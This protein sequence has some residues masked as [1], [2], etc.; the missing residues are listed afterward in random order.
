MHANHKMLTYTQSSSVDTLTGHRGTLTSHASKLRNTGKQCAALL[1]AVE[2]GAGREK[3]VCTVWRV[4]FGCFSLPLAWPSE[5]SREV[6]RG[7][8]PR[9]GQAGG[10][11]N[12]SAAT[13]RVEH[14]KH[15]RGESNAA[16]S[17]GKR[18]C[19]VCSSN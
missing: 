2:T 9:R 11:F 14:S 10:F 13:K 3:L 15:S 16:T 1:Y 7:D 5:S 4:T 19:I 18:R 8:N 12:S 17:S 6:P